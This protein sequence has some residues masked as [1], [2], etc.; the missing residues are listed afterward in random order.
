MSLQTVLIEVEALINSGELSEK[1][2]VIVKLVK[3]VITL[4]AEP[5]A[6][7]ALQQ[8]ILTLLQ[9]APAFKMAGRDEEL[10]IEDT[11]T[12]DPGVGLTF[13]IDFIILLINDS[14]DTDLLFSFD[15]V[16]Y[17][18]LH[19]GE[20]I[21]NVPVGALK[22]YVKTSSGTAPFRAWALT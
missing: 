14:V 5:A 4:S 22:L 7:K 18:T 11:A 1:D 19:P 10:T 8:S 20:Y 9:G 12:T 13:D 21:S 15:G 2:L 6:S 17:K 3:E 16:S